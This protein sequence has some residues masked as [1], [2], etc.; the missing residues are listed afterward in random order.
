MAVC[1]ELDGRIGSG[2]QGE[3]R[4]RDS[5]GVAVATYRRDSLVDPRNFL[6]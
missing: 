2:P 1:P 4:R 3:R 5:T 6:K